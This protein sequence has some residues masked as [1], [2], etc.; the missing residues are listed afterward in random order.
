M[1][2]GEKLI[3]SVTYWNVSPAFC[4]QT[5]TRLLHSSAYWIYTKHNKFH[6]FNYYTPLC[7][8]CRNKNML[9]SAVLTYTFSG[10][11]NGGFVQE[12]LLI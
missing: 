5:V 3:G 6:Y 1:A 11:I 7:V 12:R 4:E 8:Y 10:N 2:R 9:N